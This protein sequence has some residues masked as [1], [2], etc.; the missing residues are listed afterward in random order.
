VPVRAVQ[1][2]TS[3][4]AAILPPHSSKVLKQSSLAGYR[5][6][7]SQHEGDTV[8]SQGREL[9]GALCITTKVKETCESV[10]SIGTILLDAATCLNRFDSGFSLGTV[11][12]VN[13]DPSVLLDCFQTGSRVRTL[14]SDARPSVMTQGR[15]RRPEAM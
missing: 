5:G 8:G 12:S 1:E 6:F 3:R 10:W 4:A 7:P 2:A 9:G 13:R 11:S 15:Q 14:D